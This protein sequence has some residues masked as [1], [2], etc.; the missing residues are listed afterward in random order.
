MT[1]L[2]IRDLILT[3][4]PGAE[5]YASAK[6]KMD[7]TVWAEKERL[8]ATADGLHQGGWAFEITRAT[9]TEFDPVA[10]R[11]EHVL[12][13][14][15]DVAYHYTVDSQIDEGGLVIIHRFRCEAY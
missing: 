5:H 9:R 2:E 12:D 10:A 13:E 6:E 1:L 3:A 11:I 4:D 7:F 15:F 14:A 8:P